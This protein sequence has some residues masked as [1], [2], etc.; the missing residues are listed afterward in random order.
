MRL[1]LS[2]ILLLSLASCRN[3]QKLIP[4]PPCEPQQEVCDG[5]DNDCD[6]LVDESLFEECSSICGAGRSTCSKGV[7]SACNA[8][9]PV[10]ET[11]NAKD[12]DCDGIVDNGLEVKPCY[13]RDN[14]ELLNGVCRFGVNRCVGGKFSCVGWVGP[15]TEDCNGLDDDCDGSTDEGRG[16]P[17][18]MI[19]VVDYSCSMTSTISSLQAATATWATKYA[20]RTDLKFALAGIPTD[21]IGHDALVELMSNLAS[22]TAFVAE[23]NSHPYASGGGSEPSIDAVYKIS[24]PSN[25]L[26]INWTSGARKAI[27]MYTDEEPQ[28][29]MVPPVTSSQ[30]QDEALRNG[31]RLFIFTSSPSWGGWITR[32]FYQGTALENELDKVI[33]EGSC[34]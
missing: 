13:P 8:P 19:F 25:P 6:E 17:L 7:W 26:G 14:A 31:V 16:A 23:L 12:D 30:A 3:N 9:L 11:C 15:T 29:Y 34:K 28:T 5:R 4:I 33:A 10:P 32:P 22:S 20:T 21:E 24:Q 2:M 1:H 18:D 27:V